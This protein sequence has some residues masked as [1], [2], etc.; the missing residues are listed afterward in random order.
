MEEFRIWDDARTA[1]ELSENMNQ[2]VKGNESG[3]VTYVKFNG[4]VTDHS[5]NHTLSTQKLCHDGKLVKL[6]KV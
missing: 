3:L 1:S 6:L 4:N 5:G 2:P